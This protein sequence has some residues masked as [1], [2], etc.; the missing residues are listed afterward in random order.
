MMPHLFEPF[1][2]TTKAGGFGLGLSTVEKIVS[3]AGGFTRVESELGRGTTFK[4]YLPG[5]LDAPEAK[6]DLPRS[7]CR[8]NGNYSSC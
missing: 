2:T 1:S 6:K 8:W 4:I 5:V 7:F 3:L